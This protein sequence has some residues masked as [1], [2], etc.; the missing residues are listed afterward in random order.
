M[1][2]EKFKAAV[3]SVCVSRSF[4]PLTIVLTELLHK[5]KQES[6]GKKM[7]VGQNIF[8]LFFTLFVSRQQYSSFLRYTV[9]KGYT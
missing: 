9:K 7:F 8:R 2:T 5:I 1:L 6:T 4:F 3:S